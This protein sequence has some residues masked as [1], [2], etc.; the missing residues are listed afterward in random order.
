MTPTR[1]DTLLLIASHERV[2][3]RGVRYAELVACTGA[4]YSTW[5][6]RTLKLKRARLVDMSRVDLWHNE[7]EVRL[8]D[9]GWAALREMGVAA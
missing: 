6:Y 8:T 7:V 5:A 9:D 3:G 1:L 2:Y 4:P